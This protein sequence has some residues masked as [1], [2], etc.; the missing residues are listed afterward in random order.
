MTN[1]RNTFYADIEIQYNMRKYYLIK[2]NVIIYPKFVISIC[3]NYVEKLTFYT[4]RKEF[5]IT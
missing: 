4:I 1:L 3:L 2:R 5:F